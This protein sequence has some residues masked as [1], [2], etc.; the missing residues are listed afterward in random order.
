MVGK[1]RIHDATVEKV[2]RSEHDKK[3]YTIRLT[4]LRRNRHYSILL[5]DGTK[6]MKKLKNFLNVENLE[7]LEGKTIKYIAANDIDK[8]SETTIWMLVNNNETSFLDLKTYKVKTRQ[9]VMK[10][11]K[12]FVFSE[13]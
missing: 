9:Q 12:K 7:K 13:F 5:Y 2:Y 11:V 4:Y 3:F 1:L 8:P 6:K 10:E